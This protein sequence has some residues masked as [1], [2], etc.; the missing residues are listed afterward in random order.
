M[1]Q[2][3]HVEQHFTAGET[4][5]DIVISKWRERQRPYRQGCDGF[6]TLAPC[7]LLHHRVRLTVSRERPGAGSAAH[8]N[9]SSAS[10]IVP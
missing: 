7:I 1:P 6:V 3:P 5:R 8:A 10:G 9:G 2:T 4:V